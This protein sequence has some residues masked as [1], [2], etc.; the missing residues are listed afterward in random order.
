MILKSTLGCRKK[1]NQYATLTKNK[2]L[3]GVR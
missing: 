2:I 1:G 3:E